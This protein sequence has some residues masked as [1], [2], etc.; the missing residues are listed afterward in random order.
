M[1]SGRIAGFT[2][3]ELLVALAI[4]SLIASVCYAT[5]VPA[6]DG[7]RMLQEQRDQ[8]ESSYQ[9]D[10]R[11]RM[12]ATYLMQSADKSLLSLEITHDQRGADAFDTLS[13]LVVDGTS[14]APVQVHYAMDEETGHIVRES[15]MAWLRDRQPVIWQMQQVS[16]FEVQALDKDGN[17]QDTWEKKSGSQLPAALRVRWRFESGV[18]RELFLQ[19]PIG[20]SAQTIPATQTGPTG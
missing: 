14:L 6:G 9:M 1:K 12:D 5:L 17:W 20:Q 15:A 8:L 3:L 18:Q 16:S 19:I 10:R 11:L 2:L 7:F 13:M 4:F